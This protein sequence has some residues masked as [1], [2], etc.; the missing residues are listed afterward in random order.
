[1]LSD[2]QN[3][4]PV[5][6][7]GVG[8]GS[9]LRRPFYGWVVAFASAVGLAFGIS[10]FIPATTGLLVAPFR[11]AFGWSPPQVMFALSFATM[12]TVPAAPV[13]GALVDRFGARW[14]IA[15]SFLAQGLIIASM[16]YIDSNVWGFYARYFALAA[17]C[18]G[19]TAVAFSAV[20]SRWFDKR[21]GLALGIAFAGVGAGG[22]VWSLAT[23]RLFDTVGWRDTFLYMGGFLALIIFPTMLLLLRNSPEAMGQTPD[24]V[25]PADDRAKAKAKVW[26]LTLSQAMRDSRYW[27]VLATFFMIACVTYGVQL[28]L[29]SIL[30]SE[31]VTAQTAAAA[32]A[33]IWAA[34]VLGRLTTGWLMDRFFAPRVALAFLAPCVVGA[35]MLALGAHGPAAF[36]AAMLVGVAT[37]AEGNVLAYLLGRYFG[38]RHF[39]AIYATQFALYAVGSSTGPL[40]LSW[41]AAATGH[42]GSALWALIVAALIGMVLLTRMPKFELRRG[43]ETA[44]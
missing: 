33:C 28:N 8:G 13:T 11:E 20:I 10:V 38:L 17:L 37:G 40:M 2:S 19:T 4:S 35:G 6:L 39:G 5:P 1:M 3:A 18:T 31:G 25:E 24:G 27:L 29:V 15:L 26:G 23:Q 43:D 16:R 7:P 30:R 41:G 22:V 21:R 44:K 14:I 36:I 9:A 34:M 32:Q 42:Y 12:I